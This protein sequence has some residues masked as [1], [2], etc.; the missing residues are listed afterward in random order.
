[1]SGCTH[2][3]SSIDPVVVFSSWIDR[4]RIGKGIRKKVFTRR[5]KAGCRRRIGQRRGTRENGARGRP[6]DLRFC[7]AVP[8]ISSSLPL[9]A[10]A[11]PDSDVWECREE[12]AKSR[13]LRVI[14]KNTRPS[15][16]Q[17]YWETRVETLAFQSSRR[18]KFSP[19]ENYESF[20]VTMNKVLLR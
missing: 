7:L 9:P 14:W 19:I 1:M 2:K 13:V 8:R 10:C 5:F 18:K 4:S 16:E 3:L 6:A 12:R 17:G 11:C 15:W 20:H